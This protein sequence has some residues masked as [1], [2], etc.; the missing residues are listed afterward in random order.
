MTPAP[1]GLFFLRARAPLS[2]FAWPAAHAAVQR[3]QGGRAA[4][5]CSRQRERLTLPCAHSG[6]GGHGQ[7]AAKAAIGNTSRVSSCARRPRQ[8]ATRVAAC[9][10]HDDG[11][12]AMG[13]GN[14]PTL[15]PQGRPLACK[16]TCRSVLQGQRRGPLGIVVGSRS[17]P[18]ESRSAL[19][20][21]GAE[22]TSGRLFGAF[23]DHTV[24]GMALPNPKKSFLGRRGSPARM[25][26]AVG[27]LAVQRLSAPGASWRSSDWNG[28]G[29][30]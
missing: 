25:R 21:V 26:E 18:F 15:A 17:A 2:R 3:G 11:T 20:A 29:S 14:R 9:R 1:A 24:A 10:A 6:L 12:G 28:L 30:A 27:V 4:H 16:S 7:A 5:N 13:D 22:D 8:Q 19:R 23:A